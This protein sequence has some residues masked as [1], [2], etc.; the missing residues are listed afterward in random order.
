MRFPPVREPLFS[1]IEFYS[2]FRCVG[3]PAGACCPA[4]IYTRVIRPLLRVATVLG[5]VILVGLGLAWGVGRILIARAEPERLLGLPEDVAGRQ[6]TVDGRLVHVI[7]AGAGPPV[8]LLHDAGGSTF[9][10]EEHVV[11]RLTPDRR[12]VAV[13]LLG[14]GWSARDDA[15]PADAATWATQVAATMDVLG[16]PRATIGGHGLGAAV[17]ATLAARDPGRVERLVLVAPLV[18]VPV[19]ALPLPLRLLQTPGLGEAMLGWLDHLPRGEESPAAVAHAR[20]AFRVAG[21]RDALLRWL[22]H[23]LDFAGLDAALRGLAVPTTFVIGDGDALADA[24][25]QRDYATRVHD[26]LVVP[27]P[28]AGHWLLRE[29]ADVVAAALRAPPDA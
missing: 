27:V 12:V 22:R 21:T 14:S 6:L 29:R 20:A 16:I 9:D 2:P 18:P 11:G 28:G 26:A 5:L 10:W 8:V 25:A 1:C 23:G 3:W 13:D 19:D 24:A 7:D 17:A 4:V 15:L